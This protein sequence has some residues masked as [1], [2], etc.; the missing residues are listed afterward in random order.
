MFAQGPE[1]LGALFSGI[2]ALF[3]GTS[4]RRR[5]GPAR[6]ASPR[7]GGRSFPGKRSRADGLLF[8]QAWMLGGMAQRVDGQQ[9]D[10][11]RR[12]SA[13]EVWSHELCVDGTDESFVSLTM[14][15]TVAIRTGCIVTRLSGVS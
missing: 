11:V 13:R 10:D 5:K 4:I 3:Q 14:E 7:Q 15:D 9:H 1:A 8:V 6:W 2:G 12:S